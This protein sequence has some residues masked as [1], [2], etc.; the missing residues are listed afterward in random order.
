MS[1]KVFS[2]S[3][4]YQQPSSSSHVQILRWS[5]ASIP[6]G[7]YIG[8]Y[9]LGA[10]GGDTVLSVRQGSMNTERNDFDRSDI[11]SMLCASIDEHISRLN[12]LLS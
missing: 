11:F 9:L 10:A 6:A 3:I 8:V 7:I 2:R 12:S 5:R 1:E 4:M